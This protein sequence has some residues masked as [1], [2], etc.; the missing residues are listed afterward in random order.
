MVNNTD[1]GH[2]LHR[3]QD[4]HANYWFHFRGGRPT[5]ELTKFGTAK[6]VMP[7]NRVSCS[8]PCM[9]FIHDWNEPYLSFAF[10]A[11]LIHPPRRDGTLSWPVTTAVNKLSVHD[12]HVVDIAAVS[13]SNRH[14][15]LGVIVQLGVLA[16]SRLLLYERVAR[17]QAAPRPSESRD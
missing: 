9:Q 12:R 11:E 15:S 4:M 16:A 13:C 7:S 14:A 17:T 8:R 10:P 6:F 5:C 1:L 3:L 2:F